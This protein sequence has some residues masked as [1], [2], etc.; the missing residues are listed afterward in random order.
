MKK[1]IISLLGS[2]CA[3]NNA[4]LEEIQQ[5]FLRFDSNDDGQ[6]TKEEIIHAVAEDLEINQLKEEMTNTIEKMLEKFDIDGNGFDFAQLYKAS[7]GKVED[8]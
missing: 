4:F 8:L 1:I 3:A 7:G 6:V 5:A 2:L